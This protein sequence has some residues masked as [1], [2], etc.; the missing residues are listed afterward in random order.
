[1]N[2]TSDNPRSEQQN[3]YLYWLFGQLGVKD[4]NA[5]AEIVRDF[6]NGRATS[7]SEL[8]FMEALRLIR[9]LNG[10]RVG[11]KFTKSELIDKWGSD[12][13][14]K[15]LDRKRKGLIKSIFRWFELQGKI[16]TMDYVKGVACRAAGVH[17]FN[18]ISDAALTRLYH[19][20]CRKQQAVEGMQPD[21][22][23]VSLN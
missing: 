12:E 14:R 5:I 9:Y 8:Q 7:T 6:T 19:E 15:R 13:E 3:R 11:N 17:K 16:V 20:F 1:M 21:N 4:K 22:F 2:A 23:S 18:E 10:I